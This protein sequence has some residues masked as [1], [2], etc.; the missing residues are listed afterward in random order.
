MTFFGL[1]GAYV[2]LVLGIVICRVF[3]QIRAPKVD[4][5]E[6]D[7]FQQYIE[8]QTAAQQNLLLEYPCD[9]KLFT[10]KEDGAVKHFE[11]LADKIAYLEGSKQVKEQLKTI[12]GYSARNTISLKLDRTRQS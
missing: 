8:D 2:L 9:T 1:V 4:K 3:A 12:K 11:S 10:V 5:V 7:R 6:F